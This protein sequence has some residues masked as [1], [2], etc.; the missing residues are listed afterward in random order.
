MAHDFGSRTEQVEGG[1]VALDGRLG[2]RV[3]P[4]RRRP[5]SV[6]TANADGRLARSGRGQAG[7][8]PRRGCRA[9]A[10]PRPHR[11][12]PQQ[13][14]TLYWPSQCP[15]QSRRFKQSPCWPLSFG[16]EPER[17]SGEVQDRL[18][19]HQARG[20]QRPGRGPCRRCNSR[21]SYEDWRGLRARTWPTRR[22]CVPGGQSLAGGKS[23]GQSLG[24]GQDPS[25]EDLIV[26]DLIGE[27][28]VLGG[29]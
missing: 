5:W 1:T 19:G 7:V 28:G 23:N 17:L 8:P 2:P 10:V 20:L 3:R 22:S 21:A 16:H 11:L 9:A 26:E 29:H 27:A 13:S 15:W 24:A 18:A 6:P 4:K 25:A 14:S 12:R